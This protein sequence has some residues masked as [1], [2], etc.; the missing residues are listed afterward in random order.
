MIASGGSTMKDVMKLIRAG[1]IG[2]ATASLQSGLEIAVSHRQRRQQ[3][4]TRPPPQ[5][6]APG[7]LDVTRPA[8]AER[9]W[10]AFDAWPSP[11]HVA[12]DEAGAQPRVFR[13]GSFE[14]GVVAN[15]AG[16]RRY[17][18]YVPKTFD[19]TP[20][21][22]VV[23]L[24]GCTQT[25]DDFAAGTRMNDVADETGVL[26]AYPEQR[27]SA[28]SS[29]CWNWF[30]PA[31]QRRDGGEPSL[32]ADLVRQVSRDLPVAPG[33]VFVAG[34][35]AGGAAAAVLAHEY[36]D[37]FAGACVHSGLACGA[38]RDLPSALAAMRSGAPARS[39]G[40]VRA[41][42]TIVFHGTGDRTV[43][44]ANA[45]HVTSAAAACLSAPDVTHGRS[46]GGVH[47]SRAVYRDD[48]GRPSAET[49][50]LQGAGHAWSGGSSSGSYTDPLGP[51]ASREMMRFF[52]SL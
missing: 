30:R 11:P 46:A 6:G 44:P 29:K 8:Q 3:E 34:L 35:S 13:P 36:P 38:A 4:R 25:P 2:E 23:M 19:G 12:N 20:L 24:H 33:K 47:Y 32:I 48:T 18:L 1:R 40:T 41:V 7:L 22:L 42:P 45:G 27:A 17:K 51:D 26:V 15:E 14:F 21:P 31:D 52:L 10:A 37:L 16:T 49:W 5:S 28:N 39:G 43:N 50:M 9:P